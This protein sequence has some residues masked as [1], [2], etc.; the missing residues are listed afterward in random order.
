MLKQEV[1]KPGYR[2]VFGP[3]RSADAAV[4]SWEFRGSWSRTREEFQRYTE[5]FSCGI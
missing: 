3:E 2:S 1:M 5:R 4:M